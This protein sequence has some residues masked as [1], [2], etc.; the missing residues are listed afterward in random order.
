MVHDINWDHFTGIWQRENLLIFHRK[1]DH[2]LEL[3]LLHDLVYDCE[4]KLPIYV[5]LRFSGIPQL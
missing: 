1:V 2:P 3:A 4:M 5:Y